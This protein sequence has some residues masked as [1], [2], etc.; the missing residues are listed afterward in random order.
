MYLFDYG[1]SGKELKY[2]EG[3]HSI[4]RHH[5]TTVH[6]VAR[7]CVSISPGLFSVRRYSRSKNELSLSQKR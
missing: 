6:R 2:D 3:I 1:S 4:T 5:P 7:R